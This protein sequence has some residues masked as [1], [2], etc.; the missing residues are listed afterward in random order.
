M[1]GVIQKTW[2]VDCR[3]RRGTEWVAI[4]LGVS[5]SAACVPDSTEAI[6]ST[7]VRVNLDVS[8]APDVGVTGP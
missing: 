7:D 3:A 6:S 5:L 2:S 8:V 4:G 1:N